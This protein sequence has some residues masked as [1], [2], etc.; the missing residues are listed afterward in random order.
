MNQNL[1]LILEIKG[2]GVNVMNITNNLWISLS[3]FKIKL[4]F[5]YISTNGYANRGLFFLDE[6]SLGRVV[7]L[8]PIIVLN[9]PMAYEKLPCKH[10]RLADRKILSKMGFRKN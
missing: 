7:L 2:R 6:I 10:I 3:L 5:Q 4:S 1:L 8:Y 9:L